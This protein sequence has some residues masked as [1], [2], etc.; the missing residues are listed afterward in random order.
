MKT[1]HAP[2]RTF[3]RGRACHNCVSFENGNM[4]KQHWLVHRAARMAE[5]LSTPA[6]GR[7]GEPTPPP[8]PSSLLTDVQPDPRQYPHDPRMRQLHD[9]DRLVNAG[10]V[11]ICLKG[12]RPKSLG[13]PEGDFITYS[14]L[15]DR[16]TGRDGH[17][18]ATAGH[19]L[20]KL[21]EELAIIAEER[22]QKK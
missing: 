17:S 4:A 6:V 3:E 14:F 15:C 11:G 22:A 20:D 1:F 21:N 18:V 5:Y 8:P 16:W 7:V 9:I 2:E 10:C 13:G 19:P 12:C